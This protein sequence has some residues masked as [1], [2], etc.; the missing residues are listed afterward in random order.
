MADEQNI[1]QQ[2]Q[3]PE[4]Q[5]GPG[6]PPLSKDQRAKLD[7]IVVQMDKQG[8]SD[9]EIQA[10]VDDYKKKYSSP[11]INI[12]SLDYSKTPVQKNVSESTGIPAAS[13]PK[14]VPTKTTAEQLADLHTQAQQTL[15][16]ELTNNN[17]IVPQIIKKQKDQAQAAENLTQ[18][19]ERPRSDQP[20]TDAQKFA[21]TVQGQAPPVQVAPDEVNNFIQT[22]QNDPTA[23]RAFLSHVASAKPEKAQAIQSAMYTHD[24]MERSGND[25]SKAGKIFQNAE[26]VGSGK[27]TYDVQSGQLQKPEDTWESIK[28]GLKSKNQAF[29]DYDLFNNTTPDKAIQ[30]LEK[31]RTEFDPEEP[32]PVPKGF[33]SGIAGGAASQPIK[34]MVVGKVT[35]GAFGLIPGAEEFAPAVNKFMTAAVS[36]GDF[37]KM[38]YANELQKNYND[39]RNQ[40]VAPEVAYSQASQA[41]KKQSYVDAAS[42]AAMMFAGGKIGE[43]KLPAFSLSEGFTN[44]VVNGLKQGAK[45]IG[46]AGAVGL[47]QG[48]GQDLKNKIAQQSGI[49]TD[50]SGRDI[51][52]AIKSG[53]LFTLGMGLIAK[54]GDLL[55][56]KTRARILQGLSKAPDQQIN[57]ELGTQLMEGHITPEEAVAAQKEISDHREMNA[58][59]PENVTDEAKL[60]IQDKIKRR[61]YLETQLESSDKA[62]H[63]E[64]KEKIKAINDD[65]LE[66][67]KEKVP[68]N[69]TEEAN[70]GLSLKSDKIDFLDFSEAKKFDTPDAYLRDLEKRG[71]VSIDCG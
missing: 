48:A 43:M 70:A 69:F 7:S 6:D 39:L 28:T 26:G 51:G 3:I 56:S 30:E 63:P 67:S 53:T 4:Q 38:S 34:G 35:G 64:I 36:S 71:I 9:K 47:I 23:A 1:G 10:V 24:A 5:N 13:I 42:G 22:A 59:L 57:A 49:H 65:I 55:S 61:D 46:E 45:G 52:E 33:I 19:A 17:D 31:R 32:I 68:K 60:A 40:G 37:Q 27:L 41:A 8:A 2:P 58:S 14:E 50:E 11:K 16:N 62:F 21:A 18:F 20:M 29:A 15:K 44:A 12:P 25:P 54:G 66:L